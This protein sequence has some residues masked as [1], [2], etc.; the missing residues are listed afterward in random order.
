MGVLGSGAPKP[1]SDAVPLG[2]TPALVA[3]AWL[4]DAGSAANA[5]GAGWAAPR[6]AATAAPLVAVTVAARVAG[7][8][9]VP[10]CASGS[11]DWAAFAAASPARLWLARNVARL[12]AKLVC[13]GAAPCEG[14]VPYAAPPPVGGNAVVVGSSR[15]SGLPD[16]DA[17]SE[18]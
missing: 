3:P 14:A 4:D 9:G 16:T 2:E 17:T 11:V 1:G 13:D 15:T 12:S 7:K 10:V 6:L 8:P 5:P 18:R